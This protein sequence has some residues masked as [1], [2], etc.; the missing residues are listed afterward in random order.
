LI[1]V[2]LDFGFVC[3]VQVIISI[4]AKIR[5]IAYNKSYRKPTLKK[6]LMYQER[7]FWMEIFV[8]L[9]VVAIIVGG[10]K[11]LHLSPEERKAAGI[12]TPEESRAIHHPNP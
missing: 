3:H 5:K 6:G 7:S 4:F 8:G 9:L 2:Q 1:V 12:V 10:A 11:F